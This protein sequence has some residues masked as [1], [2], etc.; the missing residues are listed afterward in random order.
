VKP[1]TIPFPDGVRSTVVDAEPLDDPPPPLPPPPPDLADLTAA[2]VP[3][4]EPASTVI[5]DVDPL[6]DGSVPLELNWPALE[7]REA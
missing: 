4:S 2:S 3:P 6:G 7:K 1:T 5:E